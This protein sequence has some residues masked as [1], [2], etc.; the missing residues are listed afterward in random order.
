MIKKPASLSIDETA[1]RTGT[2]LER[3]LNREEAQKRL[4]KYGTNELKEQQGNTILDLIIQQF[5]S[6]L[7]IILVGAAAVSFLI[8]ETVDAVA[9]I[10]IVILNTIMGVVQEARAEKALA[11]LKKMSSPEA[12]I[13]RDGKHVT[14]S[15]TELVPGDIVF[16]EA[17][18][19]VPGD[20]RLTESVNLNVN[21][22]SLTG[23]SVPVD[24]K[25]DT[26][27]EEDAPLGDQKN[28]VF[29]NTMISSGRGSGIVVRTGM[30]TEMGKIADMI[31]SYEKEQTPLQ[32]NL[33]QLGRRLGILALAI[34][35]VILIFGVIRDTDVNLLFGEG[36]RPFFREFQ[37]RIVELFMTAVSLAI[38]A[39][40]EGLPAVVTICLALGMRRM[41]KRNALIRRLPA[42]ETLG[43]ASV[44]C[45]DKTGTL[46]QNQM[47][48]Q[49]GW[50]SGKKFSL[51]GE[52]YKPEG[53]FKID[54][55]V[56]NPE[57]DIEISLLLLGGLICN[58]ANLEEG[59]DGE[60]SGW[61]IIGD[62]TEGALVVSAA[63][64]GMHK[65]EERKKWKRVREFPFNSERKRMTTIHEIPADF[66]RNE[67]PGADT[68]YAAFVKGAPDVV[69]E[70]SGKI[71]KAGKVTDL[72]EEDRQKITQVNEEMAEQALRVLA[73]AYRP[74]RDVPDEQA[75]PDSIENDL[76]FAGL[77]GM[78]DPAR[79]EVK[80][81]VESARQAGIRTIMVTGDY[82]ITAA[83]IGKAIGILRPEGKVLSGKEIDKLNDDEMIQAVKDTDVFARVSPEH[84]VRI[85]DALRSAGSVSAMT[86]DGVNDAPALKRADIGVAMG[87]TGTDVS[88]ETAEMVL[89]DDNFA[90]IVSAVE[91]GRTIYANIRKFVFYLLSCNIG[92]IL[93]I[94][95]SM[96]AGIPIPLT[97][98]QILW[99][100][101]VTDGAP[102][103]ALSVEEG[104]PDIMKRKPRG[105]NESVINSEMLAG[106]AVQGVVIAA[107][108]IAAFLLGRSFYTG[109][110]SH[111]RSIAFAA[112][113]TAQIIRGFTVRS[114]YHSI[115]SIGFFSN[116][117]M[118]MA[119][120]SSVVL[121][122]AV[123]YIPFL[124]G[125]FST[126][127]LTPRDWLIILAFGLAAPIA[128]E[129]T[130]LFIRMKKSK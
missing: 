56:V 12:V 61:N 85:V 34:C 95:G 66:D 55:N 105:V 125:V 31:Q 21:E 42:V 112:L 20:I 16:L 117:Y 25:A 40:P 43:S 59:I 51:T 110:I 48:V 37:D 71:L 122:L 36:I 86:G 107:A 126:T 29:M 128:E 9:I 96:V 123:V 64:A 22:S 6:F 50:V 73:V 33:D 87:I 38:A 69:L 92:E 30:D 68:E 108:V 89:T 114:Q 46:T 84:K 79:P 76:I 11:A 2:N 88:K 127:P 124:N 70:Y 100:N 15:S 72:T 82:K 102:A 129:I 120:L 94:L 35:G 58:D 78:I 32:K 77:Q 81:A 116:K 57:E 60:K 118:V 10:A 27:L 45:T 4:E 5:K 65:T 53:K 101:L 74:V 103:L 113:V 47:T 28:C 109:S 23:E 111:A 98:I 67:L 39:V 52:G 83:A 44:I 8:G 1:D 26:V 99:V 97:P 121:L 91:E 19:Y 13:L 93:T 18:N 62:P 41:V 14:V 90:S 24:K 106:F 3:G 17:G 104:E 63:K 75:D 115:F 130:K 80:D 54:G 7:V 49:K 119:V